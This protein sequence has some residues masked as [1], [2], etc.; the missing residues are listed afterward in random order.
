Y[1]CNVF[2]REYQFRNV[3]R[4]KR[5]GQSEIRSLILSRHHLS[6]QTLRYDEVL[7]SSRGP[8][9]GNVRNAE[10]RYFSLLWDACRGNP[11]A[12]LRLWLSSV[13]VTRRQVLV[14]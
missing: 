5:W 6:G 4:V 10:Q 7:L 8:E 14:G 12:A 1:L 2:G 13:K 3:V 11:M 9:A